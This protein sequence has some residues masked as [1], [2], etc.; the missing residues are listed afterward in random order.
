MNQRELLSRLADKIAR[1]LD[2]PDDLIVRE[3]RYA[4]DLP[5]AERRLLSVRQDVR[6]ALKVIRD[7]GLK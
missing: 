5:E 6:V 7:A 3:V 4:D 2:L 1:E